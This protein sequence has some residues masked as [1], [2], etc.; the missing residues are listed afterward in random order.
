MG[1]SIE[2][3][4]KEKLVEI[5]KKEHFKKLLEEKNNEKYNLIDFLHE[6]QNIYGHLSRDIQITIAEEMGL[7]L[8]QIH[9]VVSF[10]SLFTTT[11]KGKYTIE[12]CMGTACYV[13]GSKDI[14]DKLSKELDIEPGQTTEDKKFTLEGTRC[15][16]ACGMAPVV[17]INGDVYGR[18]DVD[19]LPEILAKYE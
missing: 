12:V 17:V 14:L 13:R 1:Q 2:E 5:K 9:S 18:I 7:P 4:N 6:V 11:P 8:S 3:I 15:I 10:Y 16:G 19:D